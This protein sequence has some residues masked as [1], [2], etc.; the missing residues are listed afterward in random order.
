[1]SQFYK[2]ALSLLIASGAISMAH[3][4]PTPDTRFSESHSKVSAHLASLVAD[5]NAVHPQLHLKID[6][7]ALSRHGEEE[8]FE[9]LADLNE[10]ILSDAGHIPGELTVLSCDNVA[11]GGGSSGCTSPICEQ[12]ESFR[13]PEE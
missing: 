9:Q 6:L 10:I 3:A 13:V 5:W 7:G 4:A 12:P 8:A 1:M 2:I 11:C